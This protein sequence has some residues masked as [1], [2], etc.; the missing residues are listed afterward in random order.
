MSNF[1]A[2]NWFEV[3]LWPFLVIATV[4]DYKMKT[5]TV[6]RTMW[7]VCGAFFVFGISDFIELKTGAWWRPLWLLLMKASCISVA[8]FAVLKYF[9]QSR[10]R[11]SENTQNTSSKNVES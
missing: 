10:L 3:F 4:I 6:S 11:K 1:E 9:Y 8:L 2:V 7:V 5:G